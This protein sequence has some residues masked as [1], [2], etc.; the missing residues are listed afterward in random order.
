MKSNISS[1]SKRLRTVSLM[2]AASLLIGSAGCSPTKDKC[3]GI[4]CQNSGICTSGLCNCPPGYLGSKCETKANAQ[5]AGTYNGQVNCAGSINSDFIP[6]ESGTDPF[7][8]TIHLNTLQSLVATVNGNTITVPVQNFPS[9]SENYRYSGT[10][11]LNGNNLSLTLYVLYSS[12]D[13]DLSYICTFNG[14]K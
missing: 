7:T 13:P 9:G 11:T 12:N 6:I 5:F 8:I 1:L 14:S 4:A 3:D 10:G 2:L